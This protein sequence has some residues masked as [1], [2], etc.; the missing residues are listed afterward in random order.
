MSDLTPIY[1]IGYGSRSMEAFLQTLKRYG[2]AFLLDVRSAPYSRYKP[3]FSKKPLADALKQA[4][5][6]YV[7]MGDS[8]G[9]RPTDERCLTNGEVDYVKVREMDFYV[10]GTGRVQE[11]FRQ[12]RKVVLMCSEGKPEN[13][14]RA[15]LIGETLV[16]LD[17]PVMH[18][19]ENGELKTH[20]Q[21]MEPDVAPELP[22]MPPMLDAWS[23]FDDEFPPM[24]PDDPWVEDEAYW[25]MESAQWASEGGYEPV[26]A[27]PEPVMTGLQTTFSG[28]PKAILKEVFGY[29]AFRPLQGEIIEHIRSGRDTLVIMPTGGGKSLCYQLPALLFEGLTVVVSPLISLMED[30]VSQLQAL[31]VAA[32]YLNS[33]LSRGAYGQI[34]E[35]VRNGQV[36][37]LYVAPETLLRPGTLQLLDQCKLNCLAI[38]EA[39]CISQ[40]GH[41]FR[42]EYRQLVMVRERFPNAVCV[43]L[44]AT[45]TPRVQEDIKASLRFAQDDTFIASFDRP[46]LF[47]GVSPKTNTLQQTLNFIAQHPNQSGIV[48]CATRKQV[49]EV[50]FALGERGLSVRAYHAGLPPATRQKNQR[51]FIRDDVQIMVA[52]VAFG[53]GIDKPDVRFIL[54]VDLPQNMEHYYQQI[55]RAGRD[56]LR[57]DCLLLFSYSDVRT[58]R[59]FIEQGAEVERKGRELRLQAM[60]QWAESGVCRRPGLLRYFGETFGKKRCGECDNCLKPEQEQVDL[61]VYAQKFLSCVLRTGQYFGMNHIIQVLRGS[62][63]KGVFQR[64]H[65]QLST[66]GIGMEL[67]TEGW[68]HI[69]RQFVQQGLLKQDMRYGSLK[70][71]AEGQAVL[72]GEQVWGTL[73]EVSRPGSTTITPDYDTQLFSLLRQKRKELA[74]TNNVPPYVIFSD[75]SLQEMAAYFPHSRLSFG[76]L[77]GIGQKKIEQFADVFLPIIQAY[78]TENGLQERPKISTPTLERR[79][80][81]GKTRREEVAEGFI[82]GQSIDNLCQTFGVQSRTILSHLTKYV[83][84]GNTLPTDHLRAQSSLVPSDQEHVLELFEQLGTERLRPLFDAT[85]GQIHYNELNI[86]RMVYQLENH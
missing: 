78:C 12:Q 70:L 19:D 25:A 45:A 23:G 65:H 11:A 81:V 60:V 54:H 27:E 13:C 71:T 34:V 15:H 75:K 39:H 77:H 52:T 48:Y 29:D 53:M 74:D 82:A 36:K 33:S 58:I 43:A 57:A 41:D 18:I 85:D 24:P 69:A 67:T 73:G 49:D 4:G 46:N 55:G 62:E 26:E 44:T 63:A 6:R 22:E 8:L 66:Y 5:I 64:N 35:Q 47:I 80:K 7:F 72:R 40:W 16:A 86:W 14:H 68:K 84:A 42:P 31:G 59:Y 56:G 30:Q 38:D 51:D 20:T 83:E 76:Q 9:G 32:V 21:V 37:L 28:S 61:T 50:T 3:A 10:A 2:I 17:I 1:T 79:L